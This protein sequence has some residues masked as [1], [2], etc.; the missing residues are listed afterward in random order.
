[1]RRELGRSFVLV[2]TGWAGLVASLAFALA[3]ALDAPLPR[4]EG[5]FTLALVGVW[6]LSFLAGMLQRIVPFLAALHAGGASRRAPTPSRLTHEGAL[7]LHFGC[8]LAALAGL[9]LALALAN[10]WLAAAAAAVGGAGAL[11]FCF[12]FATVLRRLQDARP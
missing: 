5:W 8:H 11:A 3:L 9:A 4:L 1:M 6:L 7:R 10:A 12:F 2:K